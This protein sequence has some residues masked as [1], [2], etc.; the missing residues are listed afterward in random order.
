M[1]LL[2]SFGGQINDVPFLGIAGH[3]PCGGFERAMPVQ[4]ANHMYG[5]ESLEV[6]SADRVLPRNQNTIALQKG[7]PR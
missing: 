1:T 2:L 3:S 7:A 5:A 6:N 4:R